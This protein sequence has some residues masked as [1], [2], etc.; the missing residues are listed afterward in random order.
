[1]RQYPSSMNQNASI[2]A[3]QGSSAIHS[4]TAFVRSVELGAQEPERAVRASADAARR[5]IAELASRDGGDLA[6]SSIDGVSSA[7]SSRLVLGV[8][9]LTR[10]VRE[11][12][13]QLDLAWI[14]AS[15]SS[16]PHDDVVRDA[17]EALS[18][19]NAIRRGAAR[20]QGTY[21]RSVRTGWS[22]VSSTLTVAGAGMLRAAIRRAGRRGGRRA[23]SHASRSRAA[24][25]TVPVVVHRHDR[26]G[27]AR[28]AR[29]GRC[30]PTSRRR[31]GPA[32]CT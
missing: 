13:T 25:T 6:C 1:M 8:V 26:A 24:A 9:A 18:G 11:E 12:V 14:D 2:R 30:A 5:R 22:P 29:A 32:R 27:V 31:A 3:I 20:R 23:A 15:P 28:C 19:R 16:D 21:P 7:S 10:R 4:G 17:L